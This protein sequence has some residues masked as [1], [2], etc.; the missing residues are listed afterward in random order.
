MRDLEKEYEKQ[1]TFDEPIQYKNMNLYPVTLKDYHN[2]YRWASCFFLDK[3]KTANPEIMRMSYFKY[4]T[5]TEYL[6]FFILL[7]QLV[8]KM[9]IITE[10][11]KIVKKNEALIFSCGE[12]EKGTSFFILDGFKYYSEDFETIK[13]IICLQNNLDLG[14]DVIIAS[15]FKDK[16]DKA[17]QYVNKKNGEI[18]SLKEL[19]S[20][21]VVYAG[22]KKEYIYELTITTFH[23][24]L[25]SIDVLMNYTI[26]KTG[27]ASG[28]VT[29][30]EP[31][32]HWKCKI[33]KASKY[34]SVLMDK[35]TLENKVG[36][37]N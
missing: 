17:L 15:E 22:F 35:D 28:M 11:L 2:F 16:L 18:A 30:K 31:I 27:E 19:I 23:D 37:V 36:Q 34:D 3:D 9:D 24:M 29:Y 1:L 10:D 20:R 7:L 13:D 5:K 26:S 14:S 8:T 32:P 6:Y 4:L 33:K 12:D 25:D 21:L